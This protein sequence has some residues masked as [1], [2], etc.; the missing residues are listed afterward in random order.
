MI[1]NKVKKIKI[2]NINFGPQHPAAYG[3]LRLI[4]EIVGERIL[5]TDSHMGL[6]H[7]GTKKLIEQKSYIQTLPYID[8]L[9]YVFLLVKEHA[10][11]MVIGKSLSSIRF[12]LFLILFLFLILCLFNPNKNE[13]KKSSKKA[14]R[15]PVSTKIT[16]I[17]KKSENFLVKLQNPPFQEFDITKAKWIETT[18]PEPKVEETTTVTFKVGGKVLVLPITSGGFADAGKL[19]TFFGRRIRDWLRRHKDLVVFFAEKKGSPVVYTTRG[20]KGGT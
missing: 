4:L 13:I 18:I 11:S 12:V 5:Y 8:L 6:L 16:R 3:V 20:C 9:G 15:K 7:R 17:K 10:Y 14:G 1:Y 19:A 2:L